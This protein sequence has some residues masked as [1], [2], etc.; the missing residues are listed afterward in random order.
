[1]TTQLSE[2][3]NPTSAK[4]I[5]LRRK[6]PEKCFLNIQDNLE[7]EILDQA[8]LNVKAHSIIG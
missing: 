1:M 3:K 8:D 7:P 6:F 4:G 2:K 5:L